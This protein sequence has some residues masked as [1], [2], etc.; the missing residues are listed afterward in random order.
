MITHVYLNL[1]STVMKDPVLMTP[2]SQKARLPVV[3][4]LIKSNVMRVKRMIVTT[5]DSF[6]SVLLQPHQD[7][8]QN[9]KDLDSHHN[10]PYLRT[11]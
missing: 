4:D 9:L 11:V 10:S 7:Q 1:L 2:E 8:E 5:S 3:A 6:P